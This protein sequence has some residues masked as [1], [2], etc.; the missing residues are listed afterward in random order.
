M[1]KPKPKRSQE[2]PGSAP[3]F[4]ESP[5]TRIWLRA[6]SSHGVDIEAVA[7]LQ[8]RLAASEPAPRSGRR[9]PRLGR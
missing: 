4:V 3:S 2:L 7:R 1:E 6:D 8:E 5:M 9:W